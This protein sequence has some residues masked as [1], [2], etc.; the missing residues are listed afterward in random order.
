MQPQYSRLE[1]KCISFDSAISCIG[2]Y[3]KKKKNKSKNVA[4][5][6]IVYVNTIIAKEKITT[7]RDW[8]NKLQIKQKTKYYASTK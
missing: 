4:K 7:S 2:N 1:K 8:L 3:T 5:M 6:F